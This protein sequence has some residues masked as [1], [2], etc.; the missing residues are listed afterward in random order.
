MGCLWNTD[1]AGMLCKGFT[2]KSSCVIHWV[3]IWFST[4]VS[5]EKLVSW[6]SVWPSGLRLCSDRHQCS[7]MTP[8]TTS[9]WDKTH[10]IIRQN[11]WTWPNRETHCW[12]N[13]QMY[14]PGRLHCKSLIFR[15]L[16]SFHK[17]VAIILLG[18]L[19]IQWQQMMHKLN[20]KI[21]KIY[22]YIKYGPNVRFKE[23]R[24]SF[25]K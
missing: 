6:A 25:Y 23:E 4:S 1:T 5:V 2:S 19:L 11:S 21:E 24:K 9:K 16:I 7:V 22:I 12:P 13:K 14:I 10:R 18:S 3:F 15:N 20:N 8:A 17:R